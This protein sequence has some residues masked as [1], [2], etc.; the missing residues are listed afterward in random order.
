MAV[1]L[2]ILRSARRKKDN[3]AQKKKRNDLAYLKANGNC[4]RVT[5]KNCVVVGNDYTEEIQLIQNNSLQEFLL[6]GR[7][8]FDESDKRIEKRDILQSVAIY[9]C[10]YQGSMKKFIT[11]VI[12]KDKVSLTLL[13]EIQKETDLYVDKE[14][15]NHYC[16]DLTFLD[17]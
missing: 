13:L 5:L 3:L 12:S 4:I 17:K 1:G 9:E 11:P 7:S 15:V 6:N 2:I 16:F 14:D 8:V 10:L